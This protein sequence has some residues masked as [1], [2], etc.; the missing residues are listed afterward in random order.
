MIPPGA[1]AQPEPRPEEPYMP[2]DLT[3][4]RLF[5]RVVEGGSI[6]SGAERAFMALASASARIRNM[7]DTLGVPLLTRGRRGVAPT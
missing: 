3:D 5:L 1:H 7:E 4:L 6:T 2:F